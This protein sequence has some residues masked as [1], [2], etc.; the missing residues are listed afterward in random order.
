VPAGAGRGCRGGSRRKTDDRLPGAPLR[1]MAR[2]DLDALLRG[3][4]VDGELC[5]IAGWGP[6]PVIEQLA[7]GGNSFLVGLLTKNQQVVGVYY[8]H[9]HRRR[10]TSHQQ[11]SLDFVQPTCQASGCPARA[12]L[13]YD[14]R[15]DWSKTHF[16]VYDLLDRLCPHHHRLE[17]HDNWS[18]VD[19]VGK[20]AFVPSED[21]RHPRAPNRPS[22]PV[23]SPVPGQQLNHHDPVATG[24]SIVRSRRPG[25]PGADVQTR[26]SRYRARALPTNPSTTFEPRTVPDAPTGRGDSPATRRRTTAPAGLGGLSR[27]GSTR[28]GSSPPGRR[29]PAGRAPR[30]TARRVRP[31]PPR[32]R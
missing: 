25:P 8:H 19:G 11:S 16:S 2:V 26:A 7:A 18:L 28:A 27:R 24:R 6:V 30:R 1:I 12:G 21:P 23:G 31:G 14:H 5:E 29:R 4:P 15:E 32:R 13:R 22:L 20:R 9:H 17:T 10:P 3:V